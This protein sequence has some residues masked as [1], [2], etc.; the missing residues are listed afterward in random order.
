MFEIFSSKIWYG[1]TLSCRT[2]LKSGMAAAVPAIPAAPPMD[3]VTGP[4]KKFDNILSRLDTIHER[5]RSCIVYVTDGLTDGQTD[6]GQQ[7]RLRLRMVSRG[8]NNSRNFKN[9]TR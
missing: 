4:R 5:T 9:Q 2:S 1:K 7:Q 6:T 8:K 3:G